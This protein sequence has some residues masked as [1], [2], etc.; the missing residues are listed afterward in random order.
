M[1][2]T[3]LLLKK[4][5]KQITPPLPFRTEVIKNARELCPENNQPFCK[6]IENAAQVAL[7]EL[8]NQ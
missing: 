1:K 8:Q 2:M 3:V 5:A 7:Q 4:W 6:K